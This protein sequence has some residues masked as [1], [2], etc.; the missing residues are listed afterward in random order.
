MRE[1]NELPSRINP[2]RRREFFQSGQEVDYFLF[3]ICTDRGQHDRV[4]LTTARRE[5]D[6]SHGMNNALRWFAPPMKDAEP[7]SSMGRESYIFACPVCTRTPQIKADRW[8]NLVDE[9]VRRNLEELDIS[10]L[11]F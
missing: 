7:G 11:P 4:L 5:L 8:W 10:L 1:P 9:A 2:N 3:I 6:G